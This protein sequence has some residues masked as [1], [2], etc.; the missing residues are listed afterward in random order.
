MTDST[1]IEPVL[2]AGR[3]RAARWN[4]TFCVD[5]PS[6]G[7]PLPEMFPVSTWADCE[8]ALEA[9][10]Q[11]AE[12]LRELPGDRLG[13]FLECFAQRIERRADELVARGHQETALPIAPRLRDVELPRTTHQLRQAAQAARDGSWKLATI[14]TSANIRSWFAPLGPVVVF[15][16]NN[17]PFAFGSL[18]GGDF[19]AAI[20]AGN[21]VIAKAN[22]SH[23]ATTRL[24][25]EEAQAAAEQTRLP[26][27]T[28]QLIYR[29]THQDGERLVSDP[30]VGATGY[31]GSR[32][33]GLALK[34]AADKAG[35]PIYLELSSVNPVVIL[36]GAVAT[37]SDQI[38]EEFTTSCLMGTGQF[39]TNPGLIVL[40]RSPASDAF[41]LPLRSV[42]RLRRSVPCCPAAC[43]SRSKRAFGSCCR[44]VPSSWPGMR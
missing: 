22:S 44:R 25:A 20:A 3:W 1:S 23:P 19:A 29:L 26:A 12:A 2:I 33:A 42:S 27:G 34:A 9:A 36:P 41:R 31:T 11:A 6:T 8:E 16:P 13:E 24:F 28:V 15:G 43:R 21:P 39:C 17:F 30:R 18:S 40:V 5:N 35:K 7:E 10:V 4:G 38:V 14:D 32:A 37:R